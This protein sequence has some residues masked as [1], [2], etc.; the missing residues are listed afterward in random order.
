LELSEVLAQ[1]ADRLLDRSGITLDKRGYYRRPKRM[2]RETFERV[3]ARHGA[4]IEE[5]NRA[6]NRWLST[7]DRRLSPL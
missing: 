5:S 7:L 2:R 4:L 3:V 6:D 1:R